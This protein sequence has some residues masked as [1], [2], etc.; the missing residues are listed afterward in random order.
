M[1]ATVKLFCTKVTFWLAKTD[2]LKYD[3]YEKLCT[4]HSNHHWCSVLVNQVF[5]LKKK[6]FY[7]FFQYVS[8]LKQCSAKAAIVYFR[9]T[10]E[11]VHF[12]KDHSSLDSIKCVV[13]E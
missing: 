10:K 3:P 11:N 12:V 13:S 8:M 4:E 5:N 1:V 2:I 6:G 9:S 7:S